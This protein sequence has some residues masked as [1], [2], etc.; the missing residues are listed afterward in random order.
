MSVRGTTKA[1]HEKK[2]IIR[3]GQNDGDRIFCGWDDCD[4]DGIWSNRVRVNYGRDD[5]MNGGGRYDTWYVFCSERHRQYF[6]NS[7]RDHKN[8]P[9]GYRGS[10]L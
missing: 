1:R 9:D 7:H 8:L 5:P 6:I 2:V 3:E 4:N 10:M